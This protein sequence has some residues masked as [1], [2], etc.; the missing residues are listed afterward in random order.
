MTCPRRHR[1]W[2][3]TWA[4]LP[5]S[6]TSSHAERALLL[7]GKGQDHALQRNLCSTEWWYMGKQAASVREMLVSPGINNDRKS[8]LLEHCRNL[9]REGSRNKVAAIGVALVAAA[10]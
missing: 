9:V 4:E 8:G 1:I 6:G 10:N 3:K 5:A 2:Y 7:H